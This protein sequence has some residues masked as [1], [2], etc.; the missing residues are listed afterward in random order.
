MRSLVACEEYR[1][2]HEGLS[3][4]P[5]LSGHVV[6]AGCK[7]RMVN[8]A[9]H[10]RVELAAAGGL[11]RETGQNGLTQYLAIHIHLYAGIDTG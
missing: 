1:L 4:L 5:R 3:P 11:K 2:I 9:E 7:D 10:K 8:S 6:R